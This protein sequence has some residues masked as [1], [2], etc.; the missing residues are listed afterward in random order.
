MPQENLSAGAILPLASPDRV[1]KGRGQNGAFLLANGRGANVDPA[2]PLSREPFLTVAEL[3]GTAAQG[4][5]L[6]A[7]PIALDEIEARFADRIESRE[8]I[9]FDP[10]SASLRGRRSERLGAIAL[11]ERPFAVTAGP[12]SA[13]KLA[14][15]IAR[16]G[17][18][19]LPWTQPLQQWS[20][21]VS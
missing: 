9:S 4:R 2:S 5:V 17:L 8:D 16:V 15:R 20:Q 10:G 19:R 3:S 12:E 1:A 6:L 14:D 21:H 18:E 11:A 7:A 13:K